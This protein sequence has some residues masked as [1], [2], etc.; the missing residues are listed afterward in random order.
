VDYRTDRSL[1]QAGAVNASPAGAFPA[2]GFREVGLKQVGDATLLR[3]PKAPW[4][5]RGPRGRSGIRG[6]RLGRYGQVCPVAAGPAA[7]RGVSDRRF[8]FRLGRS[9]SSTALALL[10]R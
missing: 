9:V 6:V 1:H 5:G 4:A 10:V 3:S 7:A 8:I 2:G